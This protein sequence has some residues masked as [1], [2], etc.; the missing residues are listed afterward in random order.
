MAHIEKA[1]LAMLVASRALFTRRENGTCPYV[2]ASGNK[3]RAMR[4]GPPIPKVGKRDLSLYFHLHAEEAEGLCHVGYQD[5]H[6]R[7]GGKVL[8][9]EDPY[10]T[11]PESRGKHNFFFDHLRA[12]NPANEDAGQ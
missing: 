8:D 7:N 1:L 3:A 11:Q 4:E 9:H 5:N 10:L 2:P 6:Q 12:N